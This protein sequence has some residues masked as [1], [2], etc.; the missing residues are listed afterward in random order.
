VLDMTARPLILLA[1]SRMQAAAI[2]GALAALA[3]ALPLL[4]SEAL[5]AGPADGK[6][7]TPAVTFEPIPG[8]SAK[9]IILTAKAAERLGI[10]IGA[11]AEEP[12]VRK[13][14]VGGLFMSPSTVPP[15]LMAA[16]PAA[17]QRNPFAPDAAAETSG[18]AFAALVLKRSAVAPP[19]IGDGL[20]RVM[21]TPQEWARMEPQEP[22]RI[23]KLSARGG[24]AEGLTVKPSGIPPAED[25]KRSMLTYFY[26]VEGK[27]HGFQPNERVRVELPLA[28]SGEPRKVVPYSAV[29]YDA[30][31][32]AWVYVNTKPLAYERRQVRID[33]IAGDKAALADGPEVGT[34]VV[35]VGAALLYGAEIYKK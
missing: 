25:F 28:R 8:S 34:P 21:L 24:P 17:A 13:Q 27:D 23:S 11:V 6:G 1:M 16:A 22:A 19:A 12:I 4:S 9:R 7:K 18:G 14:V 2:A 15:A 31:G 35:T 33:Q 26:V 10:E 30:K 5:A 29:Y 32:T 3:V 20:I